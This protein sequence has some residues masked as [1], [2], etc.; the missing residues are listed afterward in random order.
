[1]DNPA[2]LPEHSAETRSFEERAAAC[3]IHQWIDVDWLLEQAGVPH[4]LRVHYHEIIFIRG[5]YSLHINSDDAKTFGRR[6][7]EYTFVSGM[8]PVDARVLLSFFSVVVQKWLAAS[9]KR[10]RREN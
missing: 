10:A 4:E 5:E 1:M 9:A 8:E 3:P 6:A 2:D 7:S